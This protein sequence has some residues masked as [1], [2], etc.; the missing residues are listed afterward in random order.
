MVDDWSWKK[1]TQCEPSELEFEQLAAYPECGLEMQNLSVL[2][3][4]WKVGDELTERVDLETG[5]KVEHQR[6]HHGVV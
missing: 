4:Y 1:A 2:Y 6:T 5:V 3:S